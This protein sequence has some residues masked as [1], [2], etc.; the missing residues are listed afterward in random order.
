[1]GF[2]GDLPDAR[3]DLDGLAAFDSNRDGRIG[4][5][6]DRIADFKLWR[7]GDGDGKVDDGEILTFAA[8]GVASIGLTGTATDAALQFGQV[9][10]L[11]TGSY[12]R[13]DGTS[14]SLIDAALTYYSQGIAKGAPVKVDGQDLDGKRKKHRLVSRDGQVVV[15]R[16]STGKWRDVITTPATALFDFTDRSYGM[17][18][19]VVLDLDGGG[20]RQSNGNKT[21]VRFD[22]DG[23][24]AADK[25]G[26][27]GRGE[28]LL[29]LDL[30]GD[31][32]IDSNA[33]LSLR[34]VD[35]TAKTVFDALATL[36][37]NGDGLL[38]AKDLRFGDLKIWVDRNGNGVT[39]AGELLT[40]DQAKVGAI[41]LNAKAQVDAATPGDN[42]ILAQAAF[43]RTDGSTAAAAAVG[44]GYL[45]EAA[46]AAVTSVAA[47]RLTL[48]HEAMRNDIDV[49]DRFADS[50]TVPEPAIRAVTEPLLDT[51]D[52]G[53]T[54]I[55]S[56]LL[57]ERDIAL[58]ADSEAASLDRIM[59]M[60]NDLGM[61]AAGPSAYLRDPFTHG[62]LL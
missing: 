39:D 12:A 28:G 54:G 62:F 21:G 41:G 9:A 26:W 37:S 53:A 61:F 52:G 5:G 23:N 16:K 6:D 4:A 43:K 38:D 3:S 25:T 14:M 57:A 22:M 51:G 46:P 10:V 60:T 58:S 24:G 19:I 36:D 8:A 59:R 13:T 20:V 29:V 49:F 50:R 1:M 30:D 18:E 15:Q 40:L 42:L 32:R 47:N 55:A 48:L 31:G 11:Q 2:V 17:I 35:P 56:P 45:A 34:S 7:D 27:V 44:L 33:E